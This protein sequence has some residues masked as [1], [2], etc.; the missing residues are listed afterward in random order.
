M[1]GALTWFGLVFI[2]I[3]ILFMFMIESLLLELMRCF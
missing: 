3:I 1:R 2:N